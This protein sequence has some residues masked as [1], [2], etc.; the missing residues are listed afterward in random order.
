MKNTG[1]KGHALVIGIDAYETGIPTL[2]SAVRDANAVADTLKSDHGYDV[3]IPLE[4]S[5]VFFV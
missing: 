2:Q 1:L 4:I 5:T 3:N